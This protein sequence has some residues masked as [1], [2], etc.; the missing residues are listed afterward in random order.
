MPKPVKFPAALAI[1]ALRLMVG[2]ERPAAAIPQ[3]PAPVR[4]VPA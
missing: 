2:C 3:A 4:D 1:R